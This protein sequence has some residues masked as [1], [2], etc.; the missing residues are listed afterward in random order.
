MPHD[1]PLIALLA[2][3]LVSAFILGSLANRL[4]LS[5]IVGYLVAG[6][7]LGPATPG[8]V[9][10]TGMLGNPIVWQCPACRFV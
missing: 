4:K 6:I 7:L 5:P 8:F 10:D 1:T 9:A 2:V 3:G